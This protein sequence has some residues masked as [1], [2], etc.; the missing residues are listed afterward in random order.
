METENTNETEQGQAHD[1]ELVSLE[2]A[3]QGLS[4]VDADMSYLEMDMCHAPSLD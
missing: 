2:S 3:P 1:E 4:P